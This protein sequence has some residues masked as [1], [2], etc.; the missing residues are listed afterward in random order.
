MGGVGRSYVAMTATLR[1]RAFNVRG[2]GVTHA[3][4]ASILPNKAPT[5]KPQGTRRALPPGQAR[6]PLNGDGGAAAR[7]WPPKRLAPPSL[8]GAPHTW[9]PASL[10]A[11]S[12]R[13]LGW[14]V[15]GIFSLSLCRRLGGPSNTPLLALAHPSRS[16]PVPPNAACLRARPG[17]GVAPRCGAAAAAARGA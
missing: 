2:S 16:H 17:D 6:P 5:R 4:H 9:A 3:A 7:V 10:P 15:R 1:K 8:C 14:A 13:Q 11:P 12:G